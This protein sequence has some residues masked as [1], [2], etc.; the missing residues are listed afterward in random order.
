MRAEPKREPMNAPT[1]PS[2]FVSLL[3]GWVQQA[4]ESFFATQR[5]LIDVAVRQNANTM[6]AMRE[7]LSDPEHS[8][9]SLLTELA[10]EGTSNFIEAQRI[11]LDLA[12]EENELLMNGVKERVGGSNA[13]VAMTNLMR[14]SVENFVNMQQEFLTIASKQS[15]SWLH[16]AKAGKP[17][18]RNRLIELAREGMENFVHTQK[19][20]LDV[21]SEETTLA[22]SSKPDH[23]GKPAK[24]TEVA[25][26][27]RESATALINAQKKLLDVASQQMKVNLQMAGR[28]TDVTAPFRLPIAKMTGE[29]VKSFVDAEKALIDSMMKTGQPRVITAKPR[30]KPRTVVRGKRTAKAKAAVA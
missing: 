2:S 15:Q 27:A 9:A 1:R 10:V 21:I 28:A 12:Q 6:K 29:G 17:Y 25:V 14:R 16:D 4:M 5:I 3:S 23:A 18:D 11:L 22:T 19:K 30:R 20:L 7:S 26:L 24:K 8:P 13:A